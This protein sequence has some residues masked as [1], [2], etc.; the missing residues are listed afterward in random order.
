MLPTFPMHFITTNNFYKRCITSI[1]I[2]IMI[3]IFFWL[4]PAAFIALWMFISVYVLFVEWPLL[5]KQKRIIDYLITI[6]YPVLPLIALLYLYITNYL[7]LWYALL[8]TSAFDTVSYF[9]GNIIGSHHITNISPQ[10]TW[11]G[12]LGGILGV[13]LVT[14][15]LMPYHITT[16]VLIGLGASFSAFIGDLYE[17][18]LKRQAHVKDS[19]TL[20]PGHGGLLD[21]IDGLLLV[22][23]FFTILQYI[24]I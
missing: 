2:G 19:G 3:S 15:I 14:M 24:R 6:L 10:K 1:F 8:I 21:R 9:I 4:I 17:S 23:I 22:T 7:L 18:W 16:N 11:E 5:H 20:L 13:L 12:L